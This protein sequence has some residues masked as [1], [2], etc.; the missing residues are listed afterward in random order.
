[1]LDVFTPLPSGLVIVKGVVAIDVVILIC[2]KVTVNSLMICVF[3][4]CA[5]VTRSTYIEYRTPQGVSIVQGT[6]FC[7]K[8]K[9]V[10][11]AFCCLLAVV[12]TPESKEYKLEA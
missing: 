12:L 2:L 11:Y 1:M 4:D 7:Q 9:K 10:M 5:G 8:F 6:L 3:S